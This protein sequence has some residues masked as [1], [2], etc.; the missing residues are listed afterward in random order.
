MAV[1]YGKRFEKNF[2]KS[3]PEDVWY[4]RI[5]DPVEAFSDIKHQL[6][7]HIKNPCDCL[8][9]NWK[10]KQLYA[11]ELKSTQQSLLT[12]WK[13]EFE[14]G[15]K[16]Q[17]FMIKKNQ[18]EG[19]AKIKEYNV[20]CGFIINFRKSDATEST[21]YLG[22]DDFLQFS[23][24]TTKKSINEK[25]VI[26]YNGVPLQSKKLRSNFTYDVASLFEKVY[27]KEF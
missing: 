22:I 19:L 16:D 15:K 4:Y 27:I 18:I 7:F 21:Y 6:S 23:D 25:D 20:N 9:W 10:T 17:S 26:E 1:N 12:F 3:V 11:L 13:K 8:I 2:K 24:E 5:P 14:N